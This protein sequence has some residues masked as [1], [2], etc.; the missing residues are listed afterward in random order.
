MSSSSEFEVE[1]IHVRDAIGR[2]TEQ[3]E[4]IWCVVDHTIDDDLPA[5]FGGGMVRYYKAGDDIGARATDADGMILVRQESR[6]M[7]SIERFLNNLDHYF[8]GIFYWIRDRLDVLVIVMAVVFVQ[9]ALFG[10]LACP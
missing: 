6:S 5:P 7:N 1:S 8:A 10:H 2:V 3:G 4:H 9:I